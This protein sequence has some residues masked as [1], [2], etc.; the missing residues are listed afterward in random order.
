MN[1]EEEFLDRLRI[2]RYK[3]SG[4]KNRKIKVLFSWMIGNEYI[5]LRIA[6][7]SNGRINDVNIIGCSVFI[8]SVL[9]TVYHNLTFDEIMKVSKIIYEKYGR[10]ADWYY[11]PDEDWS[12]KWSIKDE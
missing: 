1:Y 6:R 9:S 8:S 7:S 3:M 4:D 11:E 10:I 2:V 12:V 5:D